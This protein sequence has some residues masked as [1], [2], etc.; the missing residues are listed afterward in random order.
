MRN[1]H[2][3]EPILRPGSGPQYRGWDA[4]GCLFHIRRD[5]RAWHAYTPDRVSHIYQATLG[6]ISISLAKRGKSL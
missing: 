1:L 3:I 5:G 6:A 4:D 2:N